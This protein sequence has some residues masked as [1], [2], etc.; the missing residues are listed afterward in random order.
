[1]FGTELPNFGRM[2]YTLITINSGLEIIILVLVIID[3][4]KYKKRKNLMEVY[5]QITPGRLQV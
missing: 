5:K 1:L 2:L 3:Y 4:K